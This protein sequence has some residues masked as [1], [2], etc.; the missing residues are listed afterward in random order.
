MRLL[1]REGYRD[2][3]GNGGSEATADL[4]RRIIRATPAKRD[5]DHIR[6]I[7]DSN[8][9]IPDKTAAIMGEGPRPLP[10]MTRTAKNLEKAGA[11]LIVIPCNTAHF[12]YEELK[13]SVGIPILNMAELTAQRIRKKFPHVKRVGLIGTT[14]TVR[15]GIYDRALGK[16]RVEVIC[17]PD[18]LQDRVMEANTTT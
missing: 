13:K 8:P 10:E 5:Q 14:G 9:K 11:D 3:W 2:T 18:N 17:P 6:V 15:A 16:S 1:G 7:I 4:F 12:Y